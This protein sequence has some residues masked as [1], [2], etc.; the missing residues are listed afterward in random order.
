MRRLCA[1][2]SG[3]RVARGGDA[4]GNERVSTVARRE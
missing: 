4:G 1:V 2:E 3:V